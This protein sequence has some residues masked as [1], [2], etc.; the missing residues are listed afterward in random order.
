M[1]LSLPVIALFL[2]LASALTLP[3]ARAA[4]DVIGSWE[5]ESKCT[6]ADSPCRDEHVLYR[7][8][9]DKKDPARLTMDADKIVNGSSQF[10]GTLVCQLHP[11]STL[12]CTGNTPRQDDWEF[13][14]SAATMTGTLTIG[15]ERQLYRRITVRRTSPK[16]N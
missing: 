4:A 2:F 5:G 10:M 11:D 12:S 6:V 7:I 14:V 1:R 15:P 16:A 9:I 13:H 8:A 3:A